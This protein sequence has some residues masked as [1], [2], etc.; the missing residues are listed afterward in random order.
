MTEFDHD[1]PDDVRAALKEV[2]HD[3]RVSA[4]N[5][6]LKAAALLQAKLGV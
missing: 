4:L 6:H 2:E 5:H 1:I 3:D